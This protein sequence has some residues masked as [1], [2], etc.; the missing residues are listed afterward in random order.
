MKAKPGL[1]TALIL[2]P[3]I[4]S[5]L[6]G[7]AETSSPRFWLLSPGA[8]TRPLNLAVETFHAGL[9][10]CRDMA[11]GSGRR[12]LLMTVDGRL[13]LLADGRAS[14]L[15]GALPE[16][17]WPEAIAADGRDWLV[18][19]RQGGELLRLGRRGEQ[20][21][22][23]QLPPGRWRE[24][25]VGASGR[26]WL[27]D[28]GAERFLMLGG[29]GQILLDWTLT[30]L[31]PGFDDL[32]DHWAPDGEGGLLLSVGGRALRLN[33]VGNLGDRWKPGDPLESLRLVA[34]GGRRFLAAEALEG[35][36]SLAYRRDS[37][38]LFLSP[39]GRS[40]LNV[41]DLLEPGP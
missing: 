24:L 8:E 40:I 38:L 4:F 5:G 1:A 18:L 17:S 31:L 15:D 36:G 29:G 13:L 12:I 33:A 27:S 32:L 21:D 35:A 25:A 9:P 22:R 11:L 3:T 7:A 37:G 20:L 19:H 16:G 41:P 28:A 34:L 14:D 30:R 23:I 39:D 10:P 6:A 26:I 2:L